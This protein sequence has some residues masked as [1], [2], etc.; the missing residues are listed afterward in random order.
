MKES[1]QK[2]RWEMPR[3]AKRS[4]AVEGSGKCTP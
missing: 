3:D 4:Q 2:L 1:P